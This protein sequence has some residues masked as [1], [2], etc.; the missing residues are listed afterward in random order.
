MVKILHKSD[1][2]G[3]TELGWLHSKHSFSFG[4]YYNPD[5]MGF[6]MLRVLNDDIVDPGQG[7]GLHPHNNMEIFSLV[8]DG[9]LEHKDNMGNG[10]RIYKDEIQIMSAGTGVLHSEFNPSDTEKVNFLQIWIIPKERNIKPR[11]D[12]MKFPLSDR[13]NTILK[14]ITGEK[15]KGTLFINQNA[16]VSLGNFEKGNSASYELNYPGNGVYLFNLNGTI[17]A[18]DNI[19]NSRD[20]IGFAGINNLKISS[21]TDVDFIILEVPLK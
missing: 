5:K 3:T 9:A 13:R 19:L 14:I 4:E 15:S 20:A 10:S 6:G 17:L 11:Y 21:Q 1:E 8:L 2:R 18:E 16:V 12:Q 7:F